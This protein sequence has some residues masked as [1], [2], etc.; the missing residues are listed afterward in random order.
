MRNPTDGIASDVSASL[1]VMPWSVR[2]GNLGAE[3][4]VYIW[5]LL[6]DDLSSIFVIALDDDEPAD[7]DNDVDAAKKLEEISKFL[8][9][10][11]K[12]AE[13]LQEIAD[14]IGSGLS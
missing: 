3:K 10:G 4:T 13:R 9:R 7:D 1:R 2:P 5:F 12:L 6:S 14:A 8:Y 11:Y